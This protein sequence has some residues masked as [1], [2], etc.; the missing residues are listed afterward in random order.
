MFW[1]VHWKHVWWDSAPWTEETL[2]LCCIQLCHRCDQLQLQWA[3]VL[4]GLP[5]QWETR[6]GSSSPLL[7]PALKSS[8]QDRTSD[9][10]WPLRAEGHYRLLLRC[11]SF[12][13]R[14]SS[15]WKTLLMF[16]GSTT[17][18]LKLKYVD[19]SSLPLWHTPSSLTPFC[20]SSMQVPLERKKK[21]V[22]IRKE[23]SEESGGIN[24]FWSLIWIFSTCMWLLLSHVI[25]AVAVTEAP[26]YLS[27]QSYMAD[28]SLSEEMSQFD[29]STG[30][31]SFSI[32]SQMPEAQRRTTV[33]RVSLFVKLHWS[34]LSTCS[35]LLLNVGDWRVK[36]LTERNGG[37][38]NGRAE[39]AW[40][41]G[42]HD[43]S[44]WTHAKE[45]HYPQHWS[46]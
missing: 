19:S 32:G 36:P 5:L 13:H 34:S 21:Y 22:M 29:F 28:S 43:G 35:N 31:Q 8:V 23:V 26:V 44:H 37:S 1:S 14:I 2:S 6:E 30:V 45:Q 9:C 33:K 4:P 7:T 16:K 40:M 41:H 15:F 12:L 24:L 25:Y 3:Q 46:C 10:L 38:G 39:S 18:P 20:S 27:S 11:L 42:S 17:F